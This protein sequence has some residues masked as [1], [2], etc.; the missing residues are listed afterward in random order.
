MSMIDLS[1]V[2][3]H[4]AVE[5]IADV[6]CNR[7]QNNDRSFFRIITAY[8]LSV[9]AATMRAKLSTKDRGEIPV[10]TYALAFSPSGSGKGHSVGII[11]NEII[12]GFRNT[13]LETTLPVISEANMWKMAMSRAARNGTTEQEEFDGLAREY[14]DTGAFPFVFDSGSIPAIK[15]VRQ[16]LLLANCGSINLQIDE[17]GS[18][19]IGSTEVL[20]VY[21]ELYDQGMVKPK[22]TKN[23]NDNKRTE[24][25]EGKTPSN[26]LLFGTPSKLL[27]GSTTEDH[28]YSFLETGYARRCIFAMGNPKPASDHLTSAEIY[29]NLI[30]PANK[31]QALKWSSKF[32]ALADASKFD[33]LIDVPDDVAI[34][35]LEYRI[36]CENQAREMAE[37]E[38]IRKAEISH[39]YFKVLKLAGAY[40]FIDEASEL[41]M[42][43]LHSAMKLVEESG[44]AFQSIL[45]REKAYMKLARYIAGVGT[46]VTH[47]DL[48]EALPFYKSGIAA[49]NEMLTMATAWGYKQHIMLK[50]SFIDGIEFYSGETLK[51]TSLDSVSL[52]YSDDFAYNYEGVNVAFEDLPKLT[53]EKGFHWTNHKFSKQHRCEENTIPGFNLLVIDVDGGASLDTV[54]ELLKDFT[55]MTYTTKRHTLAEHRFRLILP[56]NYELKLDKEDY[57]EFMTN[58]RQWLPFDT[59]EASNQRSKKWMSND[60]GSYHFNITDTLIDVLPFVPK[61][62]KN[63]QYREAST[64]LQSLDNLERWFA[65]RMVD[66][67]RNNHMIKFALALVDAGMPYGD[68]ED[69]VMSFNKKLSNGL[70]EQE[71]KST[72]LVTVARKLQGSP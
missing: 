32:S 72:V 54:H 2:K 55:F 24:E 38:E 30:D 7:T 15:Q 57:K 9:M 56:A 46:E 63:E 17:I 67:N 23:T 58:F 3:H 12:K 59:D 37:H 53:Q 25:I 11:E 21:L 22:L 33:W 13:F 68:V 39:R 41:E 27:D 71:L 44:T 70:S 43:H 16:K 40:A 52:A 61:T 64:K 4:Q 36:Q 34:A 29:H 65:Q 6:L 50:K 10:N 45:T 8:F 35:L 19:L 66:G 28:F 49:R 48:V 69:K 42:D 18:N 5:E 20:N 62:T 51:E 1:T 26:M 14:R 60:Q 47:A 31:A